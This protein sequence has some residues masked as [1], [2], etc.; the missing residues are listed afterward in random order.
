MWDWLVIQAQ[1]ASPFVA[2]FCL[3]TTAGSVK[4]CA[5]LWKQLLFERTEH[6]KAE[7]DST[8]ASNRVAGAMEKLAAK[9]ERART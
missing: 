2:V 9:W 3:A 5:I 1:T 4:V 6:R 7:K 8:A